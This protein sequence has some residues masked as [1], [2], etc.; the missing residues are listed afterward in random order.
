M[1]RHTVAHFNPTSILAIIREQNVDGK[2]LT[3]NERKELVDRYLEVY[4]L[5]FTLQK[6]L[7]FKYLILIFV[8]S[9]NN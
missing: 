2:L 9:L 3:E 1:Q 6:S 7:S 8:F 4:L 5:H